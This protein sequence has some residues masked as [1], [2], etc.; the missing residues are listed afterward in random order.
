MGNPY[1]P[2]RAIFVGVWLLMVALAAAVGQVVV[3]LWRKKRA[4][5]QPDPPPAAP[6]SSAP[7]THPPEEL[8]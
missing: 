1:D 6:Q 3:A 7:G 5:D 4:L 8:V 2:V